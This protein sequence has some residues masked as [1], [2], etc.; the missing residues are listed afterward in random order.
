MKLQSI[1]LTKYVL[2][3]EDQSSGRFGATVILM[4]NDQNKEEREL[5][6]LVHA[7]EDSFVL[8]ITCLDGR[9]KVIVEDHDEPEL[10]TTGEGT[11]FQ[12]AWS[13]L[14]TIGVG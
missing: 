9:W 5:I 11:T 1:R 8:T 7:N 10:S 2:A 14:R 12:A 6:E 4:P 13:N 3:I